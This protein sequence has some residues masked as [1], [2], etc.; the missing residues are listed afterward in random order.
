MLYELRKT[1]R[2]RHLCY[3]RRLRQLEAIV[4]VKQYHLAYKR[5]PAVRHIGITRH[6]LRAH[7]LKPLSAIQRQLQVHLVGSGLQSS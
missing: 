5:L 4:K 7:I 3:A 1:L 6:L 2:R